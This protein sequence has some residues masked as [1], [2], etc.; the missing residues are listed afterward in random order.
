MQMFNEN[1]TA[2]EVKRKYTGEDKPQ[3]KLLE[4]FDYHNTQMEKMIGIDCVKA[5]HTKFKTVRDKLASFIQKQ[6][7]KKD[8]FLEDL[9]HQFVTNFEYYLKSNDKIQHNTAMKYIRNLKKIINESIRNQWLGQNP[10]SNFKC[11]FRRT[12][13]D[14]L[15]QAEIDKIFDKE[16]SIPRLKQVRDIFIFSCYTG[17]AY[18]DVMS[19][20]PEH[21]NIG[22]DGKVW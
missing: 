22:I 20:T 18:V 11:S 7:Q 14:I 5:T 12:E 8:I 3:K 13:R 15:I 6:Y 16:I 17:F 1:V 4:V 21:L 10:F 9:N 19:L 2:D